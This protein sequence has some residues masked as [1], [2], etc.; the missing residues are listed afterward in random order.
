MGSVI[1]LSP[2]V[3]ERARAAGCVRAELVGPYGRDLSKWRFECSCGATSTQRRTRALAFEALAHHLAK[4]AG[5][6]VVNGVSWSTSPRLTDPAGRT[7]SA[8]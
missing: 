3:V 8:G 7:R 5:A 2:D 6:R 1:R 4:V